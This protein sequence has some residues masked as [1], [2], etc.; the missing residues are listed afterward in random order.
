MTDKAFPALQRD[1]EALH[2]ITTSRKP[3]TTIDETVELFRHVLE[4]QAKAAKPQPKH[5]GYGKAGGPIRTFTKEQLERAE[6]MERE[7]EE[8]LKSQNPH[9]VPVIFPGYD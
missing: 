5:G 7:H 9:G 6:T 1:F 2:L 3:H 4:K 8:F